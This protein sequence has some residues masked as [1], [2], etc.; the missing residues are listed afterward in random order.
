MAYVTTAERIGMKKGIEQGIEQGIQK[1]E[2][3]ILLNL[4]TRKFKSVPDSYCIK[5]QKASSECPTG[6]KV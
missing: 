5:I 6:E 1:G 2:S 4:L 3:T